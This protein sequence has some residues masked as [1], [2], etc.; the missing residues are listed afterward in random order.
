MPIQLVTQNLSIPYDVMAPSNHEAA[1]FRQRTDRGENRYMIRVRTPWAF[2]TAFEKA[3]V[4]WHENVGGKI[5]RF[6][7]EPFIEAPKARCTGLRMVRN[8]GKLHQDPISGYPHPEYAE[9][10]VT[11][12]ARLFEY[13]TDEDVAANTLDYEL[14]RYVERRETSAVE[15]LPVQG[16]GFQYHPTNASVKLR[17]KPVP[18]PGQKLF[19]SKRLQYIWH[20]VPGY[21]E[22]NIKYAAGKVNYTTFDHGKLK[23][24]EETLLF[25]GANKDPIADD[26]NPTQLYTITYEF[27][28]RPEGWNKVYS[29]VT[30]KFEPI[31][32]VSDPMQKPYDTALMGM[33]F[34][35]KDEVP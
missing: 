19:F 7:P 17:G 27:L 4:G 3:M 31:V 18:E 22:E 28:M 35:L 32:M 13:K 23:A 5:V 8:V 6:L 33:L 12:E 20:C 25:W 1:I 2:C 34:T 15:A 26:I 24:R 14:I 29:G 11:F 16:H 9:Y 10:E 30:N 21:P